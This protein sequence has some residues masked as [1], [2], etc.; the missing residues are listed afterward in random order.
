M[1]G[2]FWNVVRT[3]LSIAAAVGVQAL[4]QRLMQLSAGLT[5]L[6]CDKLLSMFPSKRLLMRFVSSFPRREGLARDLEVRDLVSALPLSH[7]T[8]HIPTLV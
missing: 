2:Y 8:A 4:K 3:S 7:G 5:T 1:F 6:K